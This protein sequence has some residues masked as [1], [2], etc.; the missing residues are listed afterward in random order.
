MI[1]RAATIAHWRRGDGRGP[2]VRPT[3]RITA[4]LSSSSS[5]LTSASTATHALKRAR[6]TQSSPR[7]SSRLS[8]SDTRRSMPTTTSRLRQSDRAAG[9]KP[10]PNLT[11]GALAAFVAAIVAIA[12][13]AAEPFAHGGWFIAYLLLVGFL[14]QLLLGVGQG[15]LLRAEALPSVP[16]R[17]RLAQALLWNVGVV[18]VP[19]GVL[20]EARVAVVA[21]SV[22]LAGALFLL[23]IPFAMYWPGRARPRAGWPGATP[24]F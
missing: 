16:H 19:V 12:V 23:R 5:I 6:S 21:G 20:G 22:S 7:S 17:I 2:T 13:H 24:A 9:A 3:S 18:A 11:A 10:G 15:R 1:G 14:A 8:G 4:I